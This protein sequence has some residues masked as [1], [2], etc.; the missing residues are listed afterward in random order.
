MDRR[1]VGR[2]GEDL[3]L[4]HYRRLGFRLVARNARTR[5]GEI[6]LIVRKG[7]LTAICEVRTVIERPGGIHPLESLGPAKRRQV[8]RMATWW[9]AA[10]PPVHRTPEVRLD[11]VGIKLGRDL[12]LVDLVCLEGAL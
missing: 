1:S 10:R 12:S 9:L 3:A 6:D 11:A 7:P 8:R 2:I 5:H 4:E